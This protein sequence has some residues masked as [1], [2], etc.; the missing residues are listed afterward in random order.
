MKT[1][2]LHNFTTSFFKRKIVFV[3]FLFLIPKFCF[4]QSFIHSETWEVS[5]LTIS[6]EIKYEKIQNLVSGSNI[7]KIGIGDLSTIL[8]NKISVDFLA[9]EC[10]NKTFKGKNVQ[11]KSNDDYTWYGELD[12]NQEDTCECRNGYLM[13]ISK[14]GEHFGQLKLADDYYTIEDIGGR[15][16]LVHLPTNI[17]NIKTCAGGLAAEGLIQNNSGVS[18]RSGENCN[19]KVLVLYTAA[20]N[21]S[22]PNI[23][24]LAKSSVAITNQ[25]LRNS[26][27]S[28]CDLN[29]ELVA[30][31]QIEIDEKLKTFDK[32]LE[33]VS[34]SSEVHVLRDQYKADV[35]MLF[36]NGNVM[37]SL[38]VVGIAWL[39]PS[40]NYAYGVVNSFGAN[41]GFV[42]SHEIGHILGANH[43]PCN[44]QD[45]G[46]NCD[47]GPDFAHAHTW[48]Y[49]S[50]C[51]FWKKTHNQ[52][53]IMY[54]AGGSNSDV[55]QNFSNP[56]V[57]V[58]CKKTGIENQRDNARKLGVNACTVAN[59]RSGDEKLL[60]GINGQSKM[61]Q[62]DNSCLIANVTGT[63]GPYTYQWK[64]SGTG[65]NWNSVPVASTVGY[66]CFD[67]PHIPFVVGDIIYFQVKVIASNGETTFAYHSIEIVADGYNGMIC[68]REKEQSTNLNQLIQIS[69]NPAKNIVFVKFSLNKPAK[70]IFKLFDSY[71]NLI[72][73]VDKF[74]VLSG[75]QNIE[76]DVSQLPSGMYFLQYITGDSHQGASFIKIQ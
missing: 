44:A 33:N 76:I 56:N 50:G 73:T 43:E 70:P 75:I 61:C 53:T 23:Q 12:F 17:E 52:K 5:N 36:V 4:S 72:K 69:P 6:Q 8:N 39:G 38:G 19:V 24:N 30:T 62:E 10:S 37:N 22:I 3:L 29:F 48:D 57:T 47:D 55:I 49:T 20:A 21:N 11:F 32:V 31:D 41:N 25:A 14:D 16:V 51:L 15:N 9:S 40:N 46:S 58:E 13:L 34:F 2:Q 65:T 54:S 60:V 28:D 68:S 27:I 59:F 18:E 63:P 66:F 1:S 26:A 42:F 45:A 71:G 7:I 64:Y 74:E 67:T 35:V